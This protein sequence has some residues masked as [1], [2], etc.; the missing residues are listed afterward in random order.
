MSEGF[1]P[2]GREVAIS[3]I[4]PDCSW[5]TQHLEVERGRNPAS[6]S[7]EDY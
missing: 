2:L 7:K 6:Q 1:E 4:G 3:Y 5:M